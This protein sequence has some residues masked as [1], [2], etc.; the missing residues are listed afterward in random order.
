LTKG[1][2]FKVARVIAGEDMKV[3]SEFQTVLIGR[4][5]HIQFRC[6]GDEVEKQRVV[7]ALLSGYGSISSILEEGSK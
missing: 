2:G 1:S 4:N 5:L 6:R 3:A 7:S